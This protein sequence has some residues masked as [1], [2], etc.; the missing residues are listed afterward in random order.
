M[1][2]TPLDTLYFQNSTLLLNECLIAFQ[3]EVKDYTLA[4]KSQEQVII[5]DVMSKSDPI[6]PSLYK[7]YAENLRKAV[8]AGTGSRGNTEEVENLITQFQANVSRF[9]AYKAYHATQ[10]VREAVAK[11]GDPNDGR[12]VL[13]AF[14]RYQAA[15][16]NTT[17]ARA[18]TAKQFAAFMQADNVRLFPNL[19][20][21]PSRS[22]TLREQHVKFYDRVWAKDDPFWANNQPGNLWNCKCDWEET[23]DPCT[24][25]NPQTTIRH[26][27]LEGNPAQTGQIFTDNATY[28]K[29]VSRKK[30]VETICRGVNRDWVIQLAKNTLSDK[31][32]NC[33]VNGKQ[34]EVIFIGRSLEHCAKDMFSEKD[35]WLKN[36][37]LMSICDYI[38]YAEYIGKKVSDITHNTRKETRKLKENSDYFYYFK[39]I[40]HNGLELFLHLG[41]YKD[42]FT[43]IERAGKMYLYSI[44]SYCPKN[45]IAP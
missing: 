23:D 20:W 6:H 40:A 35:F 21:L 2:A 39:I 24:T 36:E 18:R 44:T 37:I 34:Y 13:H 8:V 22:V 43:N 25:D 3:K 4:S 15:E 41:H 32:A 27:G 33:V 28:V 38:K 7:Q 9:A 42:D 45:T 1:R 26:N 31:T 11:E 14:N 19:R 16:Y 10:Q 5:D 29:N 12:K 30:E 17:V